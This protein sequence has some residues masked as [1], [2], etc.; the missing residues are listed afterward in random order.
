MFAEKSMFSRCAYEVF[1]KGMP[2][3]EKRVYILRCGCSPYD[4]L[5]QVVE[6]HKYSAPSGCMTRVS[7]RTVIRDDMGGKSLVESSIEYVDESGDVIFGIFNLSAD[8]QQYTMEYLS[9]HPEL[10][11]NEDVEGFK[12]AYA[13]F[14]RLK[15]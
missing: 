11:P 2:A 10:L 5:E 3:P 1:Q 15:A 8:E 6:D 14:D 4:A 12:A 9:E 13:H 7:Y